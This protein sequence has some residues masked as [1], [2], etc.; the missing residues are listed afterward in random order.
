MK[1]DRF[2]AAFEVGGDLL[3]AGTHECD[4]VKVKDWEAK[5][6]S[7]S[8][9]IVTLEA[10]DGGYRQ[11]EKWLDP[12][13]ERDHRLAMVLLD[14]L[15]LPRETD[16]DES[17]VGR[18][19]KVEIGRGVSKRTGEPQVYVNGFKPSDTP[20]FEQHS[21]EPAK[22]VAKRTATQKADAASAGTIPNDDIP[23]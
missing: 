5:D 12:A 19:V 18:R 1:F 9:T 13:N 22:P 15:G 3:P 8:A 11:A 7:R 14:A 21:D 16:M 23:F 17:L 6:G 2:D 4:I 10:C 20:A